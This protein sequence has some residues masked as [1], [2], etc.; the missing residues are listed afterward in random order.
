LAKRRLARAG[1]A[2]PGALRG[3]AEHV[4]L[5]RPKRGKGQGEPPNTRLDEFLHG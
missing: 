5:K 3:S 4:E 2:R 1:E